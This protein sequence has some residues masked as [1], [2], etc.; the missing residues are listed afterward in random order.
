MRFW[1]KCEFYLLYVFCCSVDLG[2]LINVFVR[3]V[4]IDFVVVVLC[5]VLLYIFLMLRVYNKLMNE[6]IGVVEVGLVS[7]LICDVEVKKLFYL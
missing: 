5:M 2:C 6:F 4:G 3:V 7:I 1:C